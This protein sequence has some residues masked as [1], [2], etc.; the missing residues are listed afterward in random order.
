[1]KEIEPAPNISD[2]F[3]ECAT[4]ISRE[5]MIGTKKQMDPAPANDA[6]RSEERIL[7]E[8]CQQLRQLKKRKRAERAMRYQVSAI[9]SQQ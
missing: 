6:A 3:E 1:M 7:S 9:R 5:F 8:I 4:V 2:L